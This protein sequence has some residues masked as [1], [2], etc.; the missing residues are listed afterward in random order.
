MIKGIIFDVGGVL[1]RTNDF[2]ENVEAARRLGI[3][4]IH[5]T[6][7]FRARQQLE[8]LLRRQ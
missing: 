8:D 1:I 6:D 7:S 4:A 5:F 2:I 3:Q